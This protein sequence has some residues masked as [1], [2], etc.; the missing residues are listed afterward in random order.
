MF[1]CPQFVVP[2][3]VMQNINQRTPEQ[4]EAL[5]AK[6]QEAMKHYVGCSIIYTYC[7]QKGIEVT[8]E[9]SQS[10]QAWRLPLIQKLTE[11]HQ[12]YFSIVRGSQVGL[13]TEQGEVI[14]K[15]WK[16]MTTSK[17]LAKRMDLPCRCPKQRKSCEVRGFSYGENRL[18]HPNFC[19]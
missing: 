5:Q 2:F 17:L 13:K 19:S 8:W 10:C 12:P 16:L 7:V 4:R 6:R 15:G 1:G 11:K 18:L 9:W 14:S 3:S